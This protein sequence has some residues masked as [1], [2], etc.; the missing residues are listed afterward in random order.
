LGQD[1]KVGDSGDAELVYGD[2]Y[3]GVS[4]AGV[5]VQ[6]D[7]FLYSIF[8]G[9]TDKRG[10]LLDFNLGPVCVTGTTKKELT[11]A[12]YH[13]VHG[14]FAQGTRLRNGI[15]G[16]RAVYG[17]AMYIVGSNTHE[18]NQQRGHDTYERPK[19]HSGV[20]I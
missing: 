13:Q 6:V 18:S 17:H 11:V 9:V 10:Q 7:F 20:E 3:I 2:L 4:A 14:V 19:V 5:C 8:L 1:D 16:E 12:S 15:A